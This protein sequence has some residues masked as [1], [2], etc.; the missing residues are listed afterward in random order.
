MAKLSVNVDH[1]A[2]LRQARR[3]IE[4]DPIYAA[5]LAEL[6][7]C[8]GIIVHLRE[9]RRHIQFRD[10]ELLRKVMKTKLNL[11]MAATDEM[12]KIAQKIGPDLATFVPEKREELTTEGGLDVAANQKHIAK[13]IETLHQ[14]NIP[15]SLFINPDLHQIESAK[16]VGSDFVEIH[17]GI[18]SEAKTERA[19]E[20]ELKRIATA[21]KKAVDLDLRV[22]AGHGL[23]YQNIKPLLSLKGIEEFSIGHSIIARAVLVGMEQ[24]V[25]DMIAIIRCGSE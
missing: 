18:Y 6:A 2:T 22:N 21:V 5:V 4:P 1:V 25:R 17:T 24:A 20:R 14:K 8:D 3:G 12:L 7:G 15:V 16:A 9:D 13:S 11:E 23:N 10:L 19:Q